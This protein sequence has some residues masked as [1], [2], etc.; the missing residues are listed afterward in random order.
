MSI[1]N[2][3]ST[4]FITEVNTVDQERVFLEMTDKIYKN[5]PYFVRPLD[6]DIKAVFD[7]EQNP[8]LRQEQGKCRRWL[9]WTDSGS[10]IGRIAAFYKV[11]SGA[12]Q[13]R[14]TGAIGFFE[15]IN[16]QE[17]ANLL[18]DQ[19]KRWLASEAIKVIHGP[20]NFGSRHR[21]WGLLV[22]G[23]ALANYSCNYHPVYYRNLFEDYGFVLNYR[24]LTFS[25]SQQDPQPRLLKQLLE[26]FKADSRYTF[27]QVNP[28]LELDAAVEFQELYNKTWSVQEGLPPMSLDQ[29]LSLT[30]Q[31]EEVLDPRLIWFAYYNGQPVAFFV[32]IPELNRLIVQH[33]NGKIN[34]MDRFKLASRK[35]LGQYEKAYGLYYGVLPEFQRRGVGLGLIAS[36]QDAWA[37]RLKIPY[38]EIEFGWIGD[39]NPRA[40]KLMKTIGG[41][42][43]KVHHTYRL[44]I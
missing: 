44:W 7:I 37:N 26:H 25:L 35:W 17:A 27:K 34:F 43:S 21:W 42:I 10:C 33:V 30:R 8:L 31:L 4:F 5:D 40:V 16:D 3:T 15:C 32:G 2:T 24:Q 11:K 38:K 23:Q 22:D 29:V 28:H 18:F 36:M 13:Q 6:K 41:E 12:G 14:R 39:Y 9:L 1:L 20:V 19:A